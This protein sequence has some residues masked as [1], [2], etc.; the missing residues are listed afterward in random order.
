[1]NIL[2]LVLCPWSNLLDY[3]DLLSH[4]TPSSDSTSRERDGEEREGNP[5]S[6]SLSLRDSSDHHREDPMHNQLTRTP[7]YEA[8]GPNV[9]H[10]L[11]A[12]L[13]RRTELSEV[14]HAA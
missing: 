1:M 11:V 2:V 12:P 5:F 9:L 13:A 14:P 10:T 7:F 4:C 3:L 8:L 6:C